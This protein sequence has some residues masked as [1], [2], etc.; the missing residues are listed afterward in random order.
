[1][2]TLTTNETLVD[3]Y[4]ERAVDLLR[5]ESGTRNKVLTLLNDLEGELVAA[6][7]K[8]DPTGVSGISAQ[9]KRLQKLLA[10]VQSAIRAS[11]RLTSKT[12]AA[13]IREIVDQEAVWTGHAIN[14]SI[15]VDFVTGGVTRAGLENLVGDVFIQGA[16]S[17]DWWSRQAKGLQ[18]RFADQM[19]MGV[20]IGESN[21][22]LVARIRGKD[23]APGLMDISRNSAERLVRSSVQ[24]AANTGREA[25]YA[26]N[27]DIIASLQ[28]HATLDT[29]TSIWCITRDGH[30]YSNDEAHKPKDGGPPWL[31]GPGAL[32]WCCRSTS[33]PVLRTWRDLGI[34][35]DEIPQTTRASMDGQVPAKQTFE[36]WLG[37][38]PVARQ[39]T[40]LGAGKADLWRSGKIKFRD[41]LDQSGR[42]LTTEELRAKAARRA[43]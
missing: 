15:G 1:M 14:Q 32:H 36:Q 42:P 9:Q 37:K 40:V 13:E 41:L 23:G 10:S 31:Q 6:L 4:I 2:T 20:A 8:T 19:R 12:M 11:Y 26:K 5:L 22:D 16:A 17:E 27:D 39:D 18:D 7:A 3:L 28:W 34:N 33:V 30:H 43:S 29:R 25:M 21:A 38:Q 35:M 24:A